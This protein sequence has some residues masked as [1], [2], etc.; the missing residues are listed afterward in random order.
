VS[1]ERGKGSNNEVRQSV[2]PPQRRRH[3]R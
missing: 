2:R 3:L 1:Q